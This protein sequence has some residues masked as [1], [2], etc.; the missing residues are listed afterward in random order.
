MWKVDNI[1]YSDQLYIKI[2]LSVGCSTTS[3]LNFI[4]KLPITAGDLGC[5][6]YYCFKG[7]EVSKCLY[8]PST[9]DVQARIPTQACCAPKTRQFPSHLAHIYS[10]NNSVE[11][12]S[13][14]L[15]CRGENTPPSK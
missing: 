13:L 4:S 10:E 6:Y 8:L 12:V 5:Y 14:S 2:L 9:L 1:K 3:F 11:T 7:E 15:F